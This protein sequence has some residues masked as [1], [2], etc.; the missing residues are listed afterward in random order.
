MEIGNKK[1]KI[2]KIKDV[3]RIKTKNQ[4]QA[5]KNLNFKAVAATEYQSLKSMIDSM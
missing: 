2:T 1:Q 4:T 5:A 3:K